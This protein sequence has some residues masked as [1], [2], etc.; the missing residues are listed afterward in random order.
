VLALLAFALG[1]MSKPMLVTV[2]CVLLLLDAWPLQRFKAYP[3]FAL[4]LKRLVIEKI[5]F[6]VFT[7]AASV[8]AFRAQDAARA[9]MSTTD[10]SVSDRLANALFAYAKYLGKT[11]LPLD[12]A[13]FYPM[14]PAHSLLPGILSGAGLVLVT[15]F[16][17][18]LYR[19]FPSVLIGWLWFLG[20]LVPV[21]G[22]VQVG[23]Q[24]MAD[25]Y[26]YLPSIGLFIAVVFSVAEL[27]T[28]QTKQRVLMGIAGLAVAVC[29]VLTSQQ[30]RRWK[31]SET[32]FQHT[33]EVVPDNP[34]ALH[35]YG[36]AMV[37]Q[38]K[39]K[40]AEACFEKA[41]RLNPNYAEA[42]TDL[43]LAAVMNGRTEEGI[44]HYRRAIQLKPYL[45]NAHYNLARALVM[46][47]QFAEAEA[48]YMEAL[49]IK[50]SNLDSMLG[51]AEAQAAQGKTPEAKAS[52]QRI[53]T[54]DPRH[55]G[56]MLAM[57]ELLGRDG[58]FSEADA[59]FQRAVE[60]APADP[61]I[62]RRY[63][64]FLAAQGRNPEALIQL[65][66]RLH[67]QPDAEGHFNVGVV[68]ESLLDY[69]AAA[70]SYRE[71]L[72]LAPDSP[73]ALNNLAWLLATCP[74]ASVRNGAEA[75]S[76]GEKL[77]RLTEYRE[78]M[79]IGTLAAA[80]AEA[81]KFAEAV[82]AAEQA[83]AL[84]EQAGNKTLADRNAGLLEVYRQGKP[85]RT[86]Q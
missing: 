55:S 35:S 39:L 4:G 13:P 42:L 78:P 36:N 29:A 58:Q 67:L 75:V 12:L 62:R 70:A 74:E 82:K 40:E 5:P 25:R 76:C 65:E 66:E 54:V 83:R 68:H 8:I 61:A 28:N 44:Q 18:R 32:L 51:L 21:I 50:P 86:G 7:V 1:L 41:V 17:L 72:R 27:A 85:F 2:P 63:G 24:S 64:L 56:A 3:S 77:C 38:G 80:Y 59:L 49:R 34:V 81:G 37:D 19:R 20:M 79:F 22:L 31:D 43:G 16:G 47:G 73:P 84:A 14:L 30:A 46:R 9:V 26:T 60:G 71:C 10:L 53:L 33:L 69:A 23:M 57:A 6:F 52:L 11:I 48:A 15:V 45:E